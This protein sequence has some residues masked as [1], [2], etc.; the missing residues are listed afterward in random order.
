M[1]LPHMCCTG[2]EDVARCIAGTC[3]IIKEHILIRL[4]KTTWN[5]LDSKHFLVGQIIT[6]N[7]IPF[8]CEAKDNWGK[9]A[10]AIAKWNP[11][12]PVSPHQLLIY[13][14]KIHLQ[15]S[16]LPT[17]Q[18]NPAK[19]QQNCESCSGISDP[20]VSSLSKGT[21]TTPLQLELR[22]HDVPLARR[23]DTAR[24]RSRYLQRKNDDCKP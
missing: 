10:V 14:K 16:N 11:E 1:A 19:H 7:L 3:W 20:W 12:T 6:V 4:T 9:K 15:P 8:G 17:F 5:K 18:T 13:F 23:G 21:G 22:G 2:D 24:R